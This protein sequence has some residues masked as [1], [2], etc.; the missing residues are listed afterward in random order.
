MKLAIN[1]GKPVR[2]KPFPAHITI[3]SEEKKEVMKVLDSGIL[4]RYLGSW[5]E[6]FYGGPQVRALEEE[7]AEFFRVKHAVAVNSCTSGLICAVGATGVEPGEEIIVPPYTMSAT[8]TAPIIFNAVPVFA[9]IDEDYF[10]INLDSIEKHITSRTRAI[11]VVNL[12]GQSYD[13]ERIN[14]LAAKH[15][16][17]VIEDAAQA[18]AATNGGRFVG[19]LGSIGV[20]SLNFHKHIHCGEGGI[21]VTNDDHLADRV[22]LIRNHAEAVV[23]AKGSA[24][25][26]NMIGFNFRMQEIEAAIARC[27]L[28]KL[29]GFLEKRLAHVSYLEKALSDIPAI[30]AP[31]VREGCK[32]VYYVHACKFRE[33]IAGVSR[34]QFVKAVAAELPPFE[35]RES[36]GAKISSGYVKPLYLQPL[37]QN[38]RAYGTQ[39][40][41]FTRPWYEG[42]VDYSKGICPVTERMHEKELF[43]HEFMVPSLRKADLDDVAAAFH[44]VWENRNELKP[45]V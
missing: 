31:K 9:D 45:G 3:G 34:N 15:G 6:Y 7:W 35:L 32:H 5:H 4:S 20:Y 42:Q 27:Q 19:T 13:A 28:K 33:E 29:P 38:K 12:F 41:P 25:E 39:G 10:C 2:E 23:E 21:I 30:I 1:G 26:V 24:A 43:M 14:A 44:K 16:L 18:P 37:F 36:E 22:R 17:Y 40:C 8:A 11:I